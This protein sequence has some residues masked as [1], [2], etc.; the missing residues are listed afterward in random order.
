MKACAVVLIICLT[1]LGCESKTPQKSNSRFNIDLD[2][3]GNLESAYLAVEKFNR[4]KLDPEDD[5]LMRT[6]ENF[7]SVQTSLAAATRITIHEGTPRDELPEKRPTVVL[8][9]E[10]FYLPPAE[11]DGDRLNELQDLFATTDY[12]FPFTGW[13]M[14]GGF[15]TDWRLDWNDGE[16]EWV[17]CICFGCGEMSVG[18]NGE[19]FLYCDLREPEVLEDVLSE[20]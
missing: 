10:V 5:E 15:H 6:F 2:V 8:G 20:E 9:G 14:C 13:K 18:K 4:G 19:N 12:V 17:A 11:A 1:G 7:P 3:P 16:D